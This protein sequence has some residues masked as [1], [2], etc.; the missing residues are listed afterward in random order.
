MKKYNHSRIYGNRLNW[1]ALV[2]SGTLLACLVTSKY[3]NQE[4]VYTAEV[5][6]PFMEPVVME[7][8]PVKEETIE[9]QFQ[10]HFPRSHKTML[11]IAKAESG[12]DNNAVNWNCYYN[13]DMSI[14]YETR[15]K[16]SHSTFCK[17]EHRKYA[18]SVDCFILQ[19]N[20]RG[21]YC[22][23]VTLDQHLHEMAELSKKRHFQPWVSF[24]RG[25]HLAHMD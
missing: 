11:A 13:D 20:Y 17:K 12:L 6:Q 9:E 10:R 21:K 5:P 19:A 2:I 15:V 22:P 16:G 8:E 24:N 14:V 7:V 18:W 4:K 1:R 25:L 23:D 3:S